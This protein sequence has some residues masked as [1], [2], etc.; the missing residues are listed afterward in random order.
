MFRNKLIQFVVLNLALGFSVTFANIDRFEVDVSPKQAKVGETVD[1]TVKALDKDGNVFKGYVGDIL[2][3]SDTDN[4]A[5]F[6]GVLAEN[7]YKF[8]TSDQWLVKFE[9]AVK[10]SKTG[11]QNINVFDTMSDDI[12]WVGELTISSTDVAT[13]SK[14]EVIIS[15]PSNGTSI[16][17][18][19]VKL[20]WK[21]PKNSKVKVTLNAGKTFET[22]SNGEGMFDVELK[23]LVD[24]QNSIKADVLDATG[25]IIG[26][27]AEVI[28][29]VDSLAPSVKSVKTTP[30]NTV[31]AES[32]FQIEITS[33]PGLKEVKVILDDFSQTLTEG[34]NGTYT[35]TLTAPKVE[36]NY[37]IDV[38]LVSEL[39]VETEV[40]AAKEILVNPIVK[41]AAAEVSCEDLAKDLVVKNT[42]VVKMK[43]KSVI[44]WDK[45]DKAAAYNVY[46]K[47][48]TTGELEL[49]EKV[50]EPKIEINI[51]G[52]VV[53]YDDFVIKAV[54]DDGKCNVES[55]NS[56]EMTKVQTGPKEV[57]LL[58]LAAIL[59]AF[60][61]RRKNANA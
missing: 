3:F 37:K 2:I 58:I 20:S 47:N 51:T 49:V 1:I 16:G 23:D 5:E 60:I 44:T 13:V 56:A 27:S 45:L 31:E 30:E 7:T 26:S 4:K 57:L 17:A 25:K 46:K 42:K 43:S 53:E 61:L 28:I 38:I 59:T 10:F 33:T 32:A 29:N 40:K 41:N 11:K 54:L 6:P 22:I 14:E 55:T 39:W 8:K 34:Q 19:T 21:A 24:G 15:S 36:W 18:K 50:V 48:R 35:G 12:M 9:N 52:D